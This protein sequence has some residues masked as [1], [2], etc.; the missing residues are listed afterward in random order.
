[1]SQ[2]GATRAHEG[3]DGT[4]DA[5]ENRANCVR[6]ASRGLTNGIATKEPTEELPREPKARD[7]DDAFDDGL[8]DVATLNGI[9]EQLDV[10][11]GEQELPD[12]PADIP[13][14]ARKY[15]QKTSPKKHQCQRCDS[16]WPLEEQRGPR[17]NSVMAV[18]TPL[19]N[20]GMA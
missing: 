6:Y 2:I 17:T 19:A 4:R 20:S 15:L 1:M 13:E 10:E 16:V 18:Q 8:T 5:V 3:R 11:P 7:P 12:P 9:D 14:S